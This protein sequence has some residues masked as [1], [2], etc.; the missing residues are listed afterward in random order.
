MSKRFKLT[1]KGKLK[2][3]SFVG[4]LSSFVADEDYEKLKLLL[5]ATVP[6]KLNAIENLIGQMTETMINADKREE[7]VPSWNKAVMSRYELLLLFYN[8]TLIQSS[9]IEGGCKKT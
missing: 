1:W 3:L 8:S 2:R 4:Q 6:G 9:S 7:D 5:E